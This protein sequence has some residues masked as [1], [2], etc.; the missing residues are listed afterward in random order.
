V[1]KKGR[2]VGPEGSKEERVEEKNLTG[3]REDTGSGKCPC[4][5]GGGAALEMVGD[6]ER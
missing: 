6:V 5:G 1:G 3:L 2:T 4:I